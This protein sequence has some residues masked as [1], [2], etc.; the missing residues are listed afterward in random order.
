MAKMKE[1]Y[2]DYMSQNKQNT[3]CKGSAIYNIDTIRGCS[4]NC[5]SCYA[6]KNSAKTIKNFSKPI[7]VEKFT[8]KRQDDI[9]YRI[10]NSGDPATDW[11]Y[12]EKLVKEQGF[13]K[14]FCV[15]K[16]QT[17]KGF[18]G[19]FD[20]LQVSID[21]LN[22]KHLRKTLSNIEKVIKDYP[23]VKIML[24]IR[25]ISTL[26]LHLMLLQKEAVDFANLYNLPV[27]ETRVRFN[28]KDSIEKYKLDEEDY[29]MRAD[30][31]TRPVHGKK[32]VVGAKKYYD[33][34]LYGAKC[35]NCSNCTLP[36]STEQFERK[37]EFIAP[38]KQKRVY[39]EAA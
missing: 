24:R 21:T 31:M 22:E 27:L 14:F 3:K 25:S 18:T 8:G 7:K 6:K 17:L 30:K 38:S 10:G 39:K 37:G 29:E 2:G 35:E 1:T 33:C 26:D 16:L 34:D 36:W 19:Y 20:K 13:K 4:H 9:W 12:S 28:R 32:F 15:T 5:E 23:R 11:G